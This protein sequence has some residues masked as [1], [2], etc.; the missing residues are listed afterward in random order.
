MYLL[1]CIREF[2]TARGIRTVAWHCAG[3]LSI[4]TMLLWSGHVYSLDCAST[5]IGFTPIS[6]G[7]TALYLDMFSMSLYP[8]GSNEVPGQHDAEG[9]ARA[10]AIEPLAPN[11]SPDPAGKYVLLSIGMSN[12]FHEFGRFQEFAT[13]SGFVEQDH[14]YMVNG[15][16]LGETA[17]KWTHSDE[18]YNIIRDEILAPA[19][20]T[21]QQVCAVWLKVANAVPTVALP[22]PE[23][24]AYELLEQMGEIARKLRS[25]YPNLLMVF[26]SSR[27]YAGYSTVTLNPEPYAFETGFA[28]KWLVE[29]QIEQAAGADPDAI[30]RDLD[31]D[32]VSPWL[33]WGPYMWADGLTPRSDGL[34]WECEDFRNDGVHPSVS[35]EEKVARLLLRFFAES[36]FSNP[37]FLETPPDYDNIWIDAAHT[38][39]E[40]GSP[41]LPFNTFAEGAAVVNPGGTLVLASDVSIPAES[42]LET[43]MVLHSAKGTVKLVASQPT[44]ARR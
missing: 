7:G 22:Q 12:T 43:P 16:M 34:I 6:D 39:P 19:G 13:A 3:G 33:A 25:R 40:A 23:A 18:N 1:N 2:Q 37:W 14:L 11:G 17:P 31:Y 30:A 10:M 9:I 41:Q 29:S 5:A 26:V 42:R 20:L 38:G 4:A 28:V 27:I 44:V 35:G 15:A 24:D 36:P 32:T 8:G 21:E